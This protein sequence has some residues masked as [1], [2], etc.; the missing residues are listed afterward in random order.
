MPF[1]REA[2]PPL[3]PRLKDFGSG[4]TLHSKMG[5]MVLVLVVVVLRRISM[6]CL[7]PVRVHASNLVL[8][9]L[10]PQRRCCCPHGISVDGD[11]HEIIIHRETTEAASP[12]LISCLPES[13][14]RRP[15]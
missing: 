5:G 3:Q 12:F 9:E 11:D 2:G 13:V 4:K 7:S 10:A 14:D 8:T 6:F 1:P 15:E